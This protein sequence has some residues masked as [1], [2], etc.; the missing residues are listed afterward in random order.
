MAARRRTIT[1]LQVD[2][3]RAFDYCR[4]GIEEKTLAPW[5]GA[6]AGWIDNF[7]R[8]RGYIP[9]LR[10]GE[11]ETDPNVHGFERRQP[12]AVTLGT[13]YDEWCLSRIA[14]F[15]GDE[16]N[17]AKYLRLSYR[18]KPTPLLGSVSRPSIK[19]WT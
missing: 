19:Q 8:R 6:P 14:S 5:N 16:E 3:A 17:A 12:I 1:S 9:A 13:A 18:M 4:R 7:Y 15:R 11:E 10:E 2:A